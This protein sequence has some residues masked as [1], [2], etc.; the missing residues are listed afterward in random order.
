[1]YSS[2]RQI[3]GNEFFLKRGEKFPETKGKTISYPGVKLEL[4]L[5]YRDATMASC[6]KTAVAC[7]EAGAAAAIDSSEHRTT[8]L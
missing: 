8:D 1:M 6:R 7:K 3:Y 4:P 2:G 5:R